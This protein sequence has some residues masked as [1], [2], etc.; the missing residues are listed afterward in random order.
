MYEQ[1]DAKEIR[2]VHFD[3]AL[4]S[5]VRSVGQQQLLS[6]EAFRLHS[7]IKSV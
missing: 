6:F 5:M 1:W 4:K 2:K 3:T 7:G